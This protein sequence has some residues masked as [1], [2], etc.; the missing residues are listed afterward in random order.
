MTRHRI[1]VQAPIDAHAVV[2]PRTPERVI[3]TYSTEAGRRRA[4]GKLLRVLASYSRSH[5][6]AAA[7]RVRV[8]GSDCAIDQPWT[9]PL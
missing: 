5:G 2:P 3:A 8:D 1:T 6:N 4:A 7:I 9:W